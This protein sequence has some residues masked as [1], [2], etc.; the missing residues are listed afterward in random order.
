MSEQDRWKPWAPSYAAGVAEATK[1]R[2]SAARYRRAVEARVEEWEDIAESCWE[3]V[4]DD[5]EAEAPHCANM[6]QR[7]A[8]RYDRAARRARAILERLEAMR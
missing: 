6:N 3:Q 7:A 5:L 1:V 4:R 8:S 2:G